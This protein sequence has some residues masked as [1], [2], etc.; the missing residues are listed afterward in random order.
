MLKN[1]K[2]LPDCAFVVI[3]DEESKSNVDTVAF[4]IELKIIILLYCV[5]FQSRSSRLV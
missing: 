1:I 3:D 5:S 2:S 4:I